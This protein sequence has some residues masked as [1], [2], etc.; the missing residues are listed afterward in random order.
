[1]AS[2]YDEGKWFFN[3]K[4]GV[5]TKYSREEIVYP[6]VLVAYDFPD[7]IV[8]PET[9]KKGFRVFDSP[10][11]LFRFISKIDKTD[12]H[13]FE[14]VFGERKRHAFLDIDLKTDE[15]TF[16]TKENI[17]SHMSFLRQDIVNI[18]WELGIPLQNLRW[19]SSHGEN[20]RSYHLVI[21]GYYLED[22]HHSKKFIKYIHQRI[23]T[24]YHKPVDIAVSKSLQ[25]FRILGSS[26]KGH[27]RPKILEREWDFYGEKII[28]EQKSEYEEFLE[29]LCCRIDENDV[30]F[31]SFD[32]DEEEARRIERSI[33]DVSDSLDQEIFDEI[34]EKVLSI[35]GDNFQEPIL[36]DNFI[37]YNRLCPSYCPICTVNSDYD[38]VHEHG[39]MF[40]VITPT[41][42]GYNAYLHCYQSERHVREREK[43]SIHVG[44]FSTIPS[45]WIGKSEHLDLPLLPP[46]EERD[47]QEDAEEPD[48][49]Q[50]TYTEK[51]QRPERIKQ[52]VEIILNREDKELV[53]QADPIKDK[54]IIRKNQKMLDSRTKCSL[55]KRF[56]YLTN[57]S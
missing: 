40:V 56:T 23:H 49:V 31:P 16:I 17:D 4:N 38:D 54:K 11:Q 12:R 3:I 29:S 9:V 20:K 32:L 34:N 6:K 28:V 44:F 14:Y 53:V 21:L 10:K 22:C 42:D 35:I 26:K 55:G 47:P 1:M 45:Y 19:Y 43:R 18:L 39:G 57:M 46:R 50:I 51:K 25:A 33:I 24:I 52:K 2:L 8:R 30:P 7:D 36:R 41:T 5:Y 15:D 37:S 13:F 27:E 48:N